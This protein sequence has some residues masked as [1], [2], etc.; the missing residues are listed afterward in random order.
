MIDCVVSFKHHM[1]DKEWP[2]YNGYRCTNLDFSN[3]GAIGYTEKSTCAKFE[4]ISGD[5]SETV[6]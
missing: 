6:G 2:A 4:V 5:I 1:A 3:S